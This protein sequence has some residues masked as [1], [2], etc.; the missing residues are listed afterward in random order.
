MELVK[1][2]MG[3]RA[4]TGLAGIS[5]HYFDAYFIKH[6]NFTNLF[7]N[8][9]DYFEYKVTDSSIIVPPGGDLLNHLTGLGACS[10]GIISLDAP[11]CTFINGTQLVKITN[12]INS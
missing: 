9:S 12:K 11:V 1:L 2:R 10:S 5:F 8:S 3:P 4:G 7:I 6:V